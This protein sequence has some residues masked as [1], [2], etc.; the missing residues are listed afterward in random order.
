M[1][2]MFQKLFMFMPFMFQKIQVFKLK[3]HVRLN[4]GSPQQSSDPG[5]IVVDRCPEFGKK[6]KGGGE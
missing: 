1:P 2:F 5:E 3:T 6:K 4:P